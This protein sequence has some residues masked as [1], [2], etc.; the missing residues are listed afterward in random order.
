MITVNGI[1]K[2][3]EPDG[4]TL[5][6]FIL[7][8][9]V[10]PW[11]AGE[12]MVESGRAG[13]VLKPLSSYLNN[14][15]FRLVQWETPLTGREAPIPKSGPN[16]NCKPETAEI[17]RQAGFNA[18][19]LANNHTGDHGPDAVLQTM[20]ELHKRGLQTVGAGK[21]LAEAEVPLT[22]GLGGK[23]VSILNFCE[24]EFGIATETKP[25]TAP[26]LPFRN[27]RAIA[28]AAKE[29]D[30]VIVTLHGGHEYNPFPSPRLQELCREFADAGAALVFNCHTHC[31]EGIETYNG[32]PIIYSPGNFYFPKLFGRNGL[33]QYGYLVKALFDKHG[34][35]ALELC[36]YHFGD[37]QVV[38]LEGEKKDCFF[39]YLETISEP[40][41][42]PQRM[43]ALF[44]A[45][46]TRCGRNYISGS[47]NPPENWSDH[48]DDPGVVHRMLGLRNIFTCESHND[49]VRCYL[50]LMEEMRIPQ[51]AELLPLIDSLQNP[52]WA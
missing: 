43:Q 36:P 28:K 24:H 14:A 35:Y 29:A 7:A 46:S 47:L 27:R 18:A 9:D 33:W 12:E 51:A 37:E 4:E 45:W 16:L 26:I 5:F 41:A 3:R 40:L 44:E 25:G 23:T 52:E 39:R 21:N 10:C 13:E 1:W 17:V 20:E 48:T 6:R 38:P 34:V 49:M 22:V 2:F 11:R 50:S 42:D 32:T 19:M 8:G 15:E 31:P 30:F